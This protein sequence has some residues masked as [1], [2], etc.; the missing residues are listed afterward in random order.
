MNQYP[1]FQNFIM[2]K[3]LPLVYDESLSYYETLT[4]LSNY[5][6]DMTN[7]VNDLIDITGA[8]KDSFKN[9]QNELTNLK[10]EVEKMKGGEY[11]KDGS[12]S[13]S[14]LEPKLISDLQLTILDYIGD[15][16]KFV[17]FGLND[18]GY[19]YAII[20]KSWNSI[21]FSTDIEG[22]LTLELMEMED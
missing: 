15:I 19:F 14:K 6:N 8:D 11:L 10:L 18:E 5:V 12:I 3:I 7:S 9:L 20:P 21:N 17:W 4:K 16:A 2:Q 13:L 22:H 1:Q